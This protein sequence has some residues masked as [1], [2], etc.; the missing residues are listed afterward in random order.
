[1]AMMN[2]LTMKTKNKLF[3]VKYIKQLLC[4]KLH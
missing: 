1:M 2:Y 3:Y 4:E